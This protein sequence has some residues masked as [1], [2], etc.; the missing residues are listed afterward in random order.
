MRVTDRLRLRQRHTPDSVRIEIIQELDADDAKLEIPWAG[1]H[2]RLRYRDLKRFPG[3]I[4]RLPECRKFPPLKSLLRKI[5]APSSTLRSAKCEAWST[6]ELAE[7]ERLDFSLPF[8]TGSYVDVVFDRAGRPPRLEAHLQLAG[9]VRTKLRTFRIQGQMEIV[10]RRC[11]FHPKKFWGYAL[12]FFVHAYGSTPHQ[13]NNEWTRA[14]KAL[15]DAL[16]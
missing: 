15:A 8:K 12:T 4:A 7:D 9:K 2:P 5:N 14:L 6:A 10:I 1:P 16:T 13:A 11:L 3:Q